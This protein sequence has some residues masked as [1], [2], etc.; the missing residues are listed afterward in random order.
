MD[1]GA[2]SY[3]EGQ[4]F[5]ESEMSV[6]LPSVDRQ[7]AA[8]GGGKGVDGVELGGHTAQPVALWGW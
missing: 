4:V 5:I 2:I 3:E 8:E 7:R 1:A 6:G